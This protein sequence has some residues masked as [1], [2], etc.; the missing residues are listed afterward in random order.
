M[1]TRKAAA[2]LLALVEDNGWFFDTE[3]LVWAERRGCR[4]LDLP[5]RWVE[6]PDSRV[7]ILRT[8]WQDVRGLLRLR[9]D[10]VR[11]RGR[12]SQPLGRLHGER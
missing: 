11:D 1:G 3:L 5:V 8:S 2:E 10:L 6:N 12:R 7:K 9:C 4:I